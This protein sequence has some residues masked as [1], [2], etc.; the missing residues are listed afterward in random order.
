MW[1]N[2]LFNT[3]GGLFRLGLGIVSVPLLTRNLGIEVYGLYAATSAVVNIAL[4][5]EWSI[6]SSIT[7]FISK[8]IASFSDN[9]LSKKINSFSVSA[10]YVT[11]LSLSTTG[12][13]YLTTPLLVSFFSN[14]ALDDRI[15]LK[16]AVRIGSGVVC[17]RLLIQFFIGVLQARK[18]YGI[19]N[20][21][22][23]IHSTLIILSTL[24][25]A[26]TTKDIIIIQKVQLAIAISMFFVYYIC[27]YYLGF[28]SIYFFSKPTFLHF[29]DISKYG[30]RMWIA[31]LGTTLFSQFDRLIILR[32]LGAEWA[33]IYSAITSVA[34]QINVISS[35]PI[36]PLLPN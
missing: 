18:S 6:S 25:I 1:K 34:N 35:M 32:L 14:L 36:Q 28:I 31:S 2:S 16:E 17:V 4:F 5:S 3:V 10:I 9:G 12:L 30:L 29:I 27:S 24:Y 13:I 7:V 26:S 33:G 15:I 8:D 23:T 19:I 21:L 22:S 20:L 11:L